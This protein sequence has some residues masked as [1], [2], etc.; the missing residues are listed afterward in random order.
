MPRLMPAEQRIN[1]ATGASVPQRPEPWTDDGAIAQLPGVPE[2]HRALTDCRRC[3]VEGYL[4]RACPTAFFGEKRP[5]MLVGQAPGPGGRGIPFGSPGSDRKLTAWFRA[6]GFDPAD[7]WRERMYITAITKCFPGKATGGAGDRVP[8][9]AEQALCRPWLDRQMALVEPKII[10]LVGSLAIR[11]FLRPLG[12][13]DLS[14][15]VVVG[16]RFSDG[17]GRLL[18]PLP[19]PSGV[20]RWL[21]RPESE[22]KVSAA[23]ALLGLALV[24]LD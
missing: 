9:P 18:L 12:Q 3:E 23:M 13:R 10:L 2:L 7:Q 20:S 17:A 19:H 4:V 1:R 16:R 21:N 22:A 24:G 11:T 8:S 6:A 5:M 15:D 14:L